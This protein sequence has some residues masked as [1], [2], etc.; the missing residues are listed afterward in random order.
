M[1]YCWLFSKTPLTDAFRLVANA[2]I[3]VAMRCESSPGTINT[4]HRENTSNIATLNSLAWA[5][6]MTVEAAAG[7]VAIC[8]KSRLG[9]GKGLPLELEAAPSSIDSYVFSI[10]DTRKH[11]Y[12]R[13]Q[14]CSFWVDF[15]YLC[16]FLVD[17][18]AI[19]RWWWQ[20]LF[21]I[22]LSLCC[23]IFFV[24]LIAIGAFLTVI[25]LV[26]IE[27][28]MYHDD[29]YV[30]KCRYSEYDERLSYVLSVVLRPKARF[31]QR[32]I[33]TAPAS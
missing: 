12:C 18:S 20:W 26:C 1:C 22:S 24:L 15:Q 21:C 29:E 25:L 30:S 2:S 14:K 10:V 28:I 7:A 9:S 33:L 3:A 23:H 31:S 11:I 27:S 13:H 6:D 32:F 19:A 16:V 4:F 17:R 8:P 5:W